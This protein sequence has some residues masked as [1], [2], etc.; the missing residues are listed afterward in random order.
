M[1]VDVVHPFAPV[2]A[3][4]TNEPRL[5]PTLV[6]YVLDQAFLVGEAAGASRAGKFLGLHAQ[7][8]KAFLAIASR[9]VAG[10]YNVLGVQLWGY[11]VA[12]VAALLEGGH[13][14]EALV[15]CHGF[16]VLQA[17]LPVC[18]RKRRMGRGY[19]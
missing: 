2:F 9:L 3:V 17:G 16:D 7:S 5:L 19:S 6:L 11:L 8:V 15:R 12:E 18:K 13:R 1:L 10:S 4:R 14:L